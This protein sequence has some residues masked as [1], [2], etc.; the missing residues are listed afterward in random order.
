MNDPTI[1]GQL[2]LSLLSW[3]DREL[4]HDAAVNC[5]RLLR[6]ADAYP[7]DVDVA[8]GCRRRASGEAVFALAVAEGRA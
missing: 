7:G 1:A 3:L 8:S 6:I 4:I 5:E 2:N